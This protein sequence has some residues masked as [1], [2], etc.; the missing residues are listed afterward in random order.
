[1][2]PQIILICI[3]NKKVKVNTDDFEPMKHFHFYALCF[4]PSRG[5]AYDRKVYR[6]YFFFCLQRYRKCFALDLALE[7]ALVVSGFG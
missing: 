7:E 3:R 5:G 4:Q 1:M 2:Y 6:D